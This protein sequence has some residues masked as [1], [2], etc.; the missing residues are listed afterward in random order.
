MFAEQGGA[1]TRNRLE[2]RYSMSGCAAVLAELFANDS[3]GR[4][5]G[6]PVSDLLTDGFEGHK[7]SDNHTMVP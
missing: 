1:G 3:E 4:L 6:F 2:A 5:G 7:R